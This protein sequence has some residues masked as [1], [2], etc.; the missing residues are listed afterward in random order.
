ML[1]E[2]NRH[3]RVLVL[4]PLLGMT[5]SACTLVPPDG[6]N[7]NDVL[8]MIDS[9]LDQAVQQYTAL[10]EALPDTLFPRTADPDGTLRTSNSA[11]WT[12]GFFPGSLWYLYEYTGDR[13]LEQ[14]ALARTR[15]LE[16]EKLNASDHDIGFKIYSS[17]GHAWQLTG[18][19]AFFRVLMTAAST[20]ATRFNPRVGAIRSWGARSD[21]AGPYVVIIDNMMNLELLFWAAKHGGERRLFDIAVSHADKT[22]EHHFR[23]DG[24]SYHVVEYDPLTGEV[25]RKGTEQG[26]SDSSAWAR[27]QA[28]G[29]Y[30]FT[31]AF[32][33]TGYARYL[34]QAEKIAHFMLRHP[35]LPDD[36]MPYWDFDAPEIPNTYRDASAAAIT[37]SA[38]LELSRFTEDSLRAVYRDHAGKILQTL[39]RPPYR[40][41]PGGKTHFLLRHGVGN[42]PGRSEVDVP[43][44]YADYYYVEALLR[45]RQI[46]QGSIES[47]RLVPIGTGWAQSSVNAVIF[48]QHGLVTHDSTQYA[49]YYDRDGRMV[50]AQRTLGGTD[51]QIHRTRYSGN[52]RDAHNT[53]S[54]G[55]DGRGVLHVSW[56]QHDGPL[57]YARSTVP[58]GLE[59]TDPL[60]MTGEDEQRVTYPQFYDLP[61][62]DLI[63][64]YRDGA[65]GDGDVVINRYDAS[66][67][68]WKPVQHPLIDGEGRRN[69]YVNQLAVDQRGGWHLSW[70]WRETW[71]VA[72]N[73]D[74]LYAYSP[75]EG[76]TWQRS[77]GERYTLPITEANAEV[78]FAIP[79]GRGLIN[80]TTMAVDARGRPYIATYWQP[81]GSDVPQYQLV[82]N[83]G[84]R[85][86][87]APVGHRSTP[88]ALAGGGT[89]RIPLS[90]PQVLTGTDGAVYLV[91]RD[92]ERG[93]GISIVVS[94]DAERDDWRIRELYTASVGLWEP[95]HDPVVW[96]RDRQ[97]HLLVQHV[98]QGEEE[99]LEDIAPQPVMILEWDVHPFR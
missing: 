6:R 53:I 29:L 3:V 68:Q 51:W 14:R 32:R 62:G 82:W 18:D 65:S 78:A 91:F 25:L 9:S 61:N 36:G 58:G 64:L 71:N 49:A 43:L 24:S 37:A 95:V 44:S 11:W 80:Q 33:E 13:D 4:T 50:L 10:D 74:I 89:R 69:A 83:D 34:K 93:G 21:T 67:D 57:R 60:P 26:Y 87:A 35:H 19:S 79:Q 39:S 22:L 30:G 76:V 96:K 98:G 31:M 46:L 2:L 59:L 72:T 70:T 54:F 81:D 28:W 92:F 48:R 63:F 90:R 99:T 84:G 73:H 52:V 66:A 17:F 23:P 94:T 77:T 47:V 41:E 7:D 38:L 20:L 5:I 27:G 45:H 1:G 15:A 85:W 42:L 88:L 97:L 8:A 75:D 86:R 56:D 40:T 16:R 55:I 12:S